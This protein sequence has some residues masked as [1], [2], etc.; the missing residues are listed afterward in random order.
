MGYET[1][2]VGEAPVKPVFDNGHAR[3]TVPSVRQRGRAT[4]A[5]VIRDIFAE[6]FP[7]PVSVLDVTYG[8]GGF[9][10]WPYQAAGITLTT[11][12]LDLRRKADHHWDFRFLSDGPCPRGSFDVICFDP[13]FTAAGCSEW[14]HRYGLCRKHRGPRNTV[15]VGLWLIQGVGHACMVAK[16]GVIV[17]YKDCV[18]S[19][20]LAAHW[21]AAIVCARAIGW[22]PADEWRVNGARPQPTGRTYTTRP[23]PVRYV[24]LKP[25]LGAVSLP[26]AL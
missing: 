18:E 7:G 13:P 8:L 9:W 15:E 10:R 22:E 21:E 4:S 3:I 16:K 1:T 25:R 26:M 24:V 17:K 14:A 12:D 2:Q 23:E 5:H 11:S 6:H 20:E 19:G